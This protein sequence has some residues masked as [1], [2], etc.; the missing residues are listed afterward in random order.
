MEDRATR[1][2]FDKFTPHFEPSR[3]QFALSFIREHARETSKVID[4]GCGD[5]GT[6]WLVKSKTSARDL[7]GMDISA[8]Y[9]RRAQ[10]NV[11]CKTIL[12]SIL[13]DELV[14]R[15]A[16]E[17]DICILGAVLHHLVAPS[18]KASYDAAF[19]CLSNSMALLKPNG[20]LVIFEPT[21][22][23]AP[24]MTA[25][26]YAKKLLGG[27]YGGRLELLRT[28]AN[29]GQ[30]VVSYYTPRQ[31]T[32]MISGLRDTRVVLR[33]VVDQRRMGLVIERVGLGL[34]LRNDAAEDPSRRDIDVAHLTSTRDVLPRVAL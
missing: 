21:H 24:V 19:A 3:F 5:G 22:G 20:H 18:R 6:L 8:N 17:Y 30:P 10:A 9:L 25:V 34:V 16:G 7:T 29:F 13:D 27:L 28:W 15:H 31:L 26:F 11:G 2:Y 23:P 4:V 33:T 32:E 12:G 14:A 1:E